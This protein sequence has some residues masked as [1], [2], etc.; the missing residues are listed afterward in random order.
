VVQNEENETRLVELGLEEYPDLKNVVA[1]LR[2][3]QAS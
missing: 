3:Q 1:Q 2:E